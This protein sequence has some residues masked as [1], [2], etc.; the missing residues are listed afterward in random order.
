MKKGFTISIPTP[1]HESWSDMTPV[2]K[3]RFCES[4]QKA[5]TDFTV[6]SDQQI[7]DFLKTHPGNHCGRFLP[8][9]LNTPIQALS[10][11]R[12]RFIPAAVFAGFTS[13]LALFTQQSKAAAKEKQVTMQFPVVIAPEEQTNLITAEN[14]SSSYIIKG[15]HS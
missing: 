4:C 3:G 1:C 6:M 2:E 5:V 13:L 9:Q 12:H 7:I 10:Q 14:D 11:E 15:E 8:D